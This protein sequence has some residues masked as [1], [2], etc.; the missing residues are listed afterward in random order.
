MA[1]EYAPVPP[2]LVPAAACMAA[3]AH[4]HLSTESIAPQRHAVEWIASLS[5]Q[6]TSK[7]PGV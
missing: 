4:H 7:L 2:L 5:V 1:L 3:A 6:V